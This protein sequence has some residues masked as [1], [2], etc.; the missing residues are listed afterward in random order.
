MGCLGIRRYLGEAVSDDLDTLALLKSST[1]TRPTVVTKTARPEPT[2]TYVR[3]TEPSTC[4]KHPV[5]VPGWDGTLE[6]LAQAVENL[7][8]DKTAE[9]LEHLSNSFTKRS[10]SD[11]EAG[12]PKLSNALYSAAHRTTV[13]RDYVW[14][15]W[16]VCKP[17]MT[18]VK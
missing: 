16:I 1:K 8:Y 17:F 9:F 18:K 11:R 7:R 12:K 15:A 3:T 4:S 10:K 6:E 2:N 13:V 14:D 5:G